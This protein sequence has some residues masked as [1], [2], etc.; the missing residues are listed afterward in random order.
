MCS[1]VVTDVHAN[2]V[3]HDLTAQLDVNDSGHMKCIIRCTTMLYHHGML[4]S[5]CVHGRDAQRANC[6]QHLVVSTGITSNLL[7]ACTMLVPSR[8]VRLEIVSGAGARP[9]FGPV[10]EPCTEWR[11]PCYV[12]FLSSTAH[13]AVPYLPATLSAVQTGR[14]VVKLR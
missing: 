5:T 4:P 1:F 10:A 14:H 12:F 7:L 2:C 9:K 13:C 11:A 3:L 8:T 6:T